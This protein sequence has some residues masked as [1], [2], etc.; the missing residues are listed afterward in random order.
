MEG[1]ITEERHLNNLNEIKEFLE[2]N[3]IP[4]EIDTEDNRIFYLKE[5]KLELRY[6][7][8]EN[9][10]MD[11]TKRFGIVGI[12]HNYFIDI[13]LENKEKGIRTVWVKD[14]EVETRKTIIDI[15]G[16]EL[17]DYRRKWNVLQS[18]I[19]TAV[20]QIECRIYARD[21]EVREVPG[22][23]L[24][25]FLETNCFYGYRSANKNL[26]LYLK[27]DKNGVKAGTLLM[28]YT[29]GHAYFGKGLYS[30]EVI[31]VGTKLFCQVIGGASKL[32]KYF[33]VNYPTLK[34]SG[35]EIKV[36]NIVYIVDGDHNDGRSLETLGF[37]F[38]SHHGAGFMNVDT[39]TGEVFHRRPMR[40]KE[41]MDKMAKGL[42]Y[43]VGNAGNMIYVLER[44][45]YML[46]HNIKCAESV[47][48]QGG[49]V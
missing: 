19:K 13:T 42:V 28:I 11:Y 30:V 16:E 46:E 26:G 15:N 45:T 12:P 18:Y 49:T 21:C 6:V 37:T 43:S 10:K 9:F 23:E 41:I 40:H 25:A 34:M 7:D 3:N 33:L 35:K 2:K 8:S 47:Q 29:F 38:V 22:K 5:G 24:R 14:W 1:K 31:R 36:T 20:G 39:T 4:F 48:L 32:L 17:K 44:D 27:K